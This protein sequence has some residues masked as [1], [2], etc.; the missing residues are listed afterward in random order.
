MPGFTIVEKKH[1]KF[2]WMNIHSM[3]GRFYCPNPKCKS[4]WSSTLCSTNMKYLFDESKERGEIIIF[5]EF[6][7]QCKRCNRMVRQKFDLEAT[8]KALSKLIERIKKEFYYHQ[9]TSFD[10][11]T[12]HSR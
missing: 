2:K 12:R 4:N 11:T 6:G 8:E 5:K 10:E 1:L 7:Q 3:Y 9:P